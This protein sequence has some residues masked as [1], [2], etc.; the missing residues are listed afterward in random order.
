MAGVWATSCGGSHAPDFA[1]EFGGPDRL[2]TNEYAFH[3]PT[4][5]GIARS[6]Q[7]FVTSGSLFVRSG[8]ATNGRLDHASVDAGSSTG[9]NSAVFRGYTKRRFRP[10]FRV[11]FNLRIETGR[12]PARRITSTRGT[13]SI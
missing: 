13:G 7:W 3:N 1:A 5:D 12:E 2:I 10:D 11:T 9:T 8:S 4:A 6:A